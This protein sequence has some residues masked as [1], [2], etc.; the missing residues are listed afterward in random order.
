MPTFVRR[1]SRAFP[2]SPISGQESFGPFDPDSKNGI[3]LGIR[4]EKDVEIFGD[5]ALPWSGVDDESY[6]ILI[7]GM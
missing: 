3:E 5:G 7:I 4:V 6:R 1:A 2:A